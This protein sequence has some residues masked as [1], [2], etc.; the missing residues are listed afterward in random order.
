MGTQGC[1]EEQA[2]G[3]LRQAAAHE[4]QTIVEIAHRIIDQHNNSR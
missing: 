1:T 4:E 2:E 3:L